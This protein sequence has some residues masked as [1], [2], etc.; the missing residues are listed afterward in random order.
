MQASVD[1]DRATSY[2]GAILMAWRFVYWSTFVLT[3]FV[4][5]VLQEYWY[6]GDFS[7]RARLRSAVMANVKVRL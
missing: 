5:P 7:P 3:W 6:A 2:N 1:D 4:L